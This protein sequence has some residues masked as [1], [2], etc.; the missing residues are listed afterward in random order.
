MAEQLPVN[1]HTG[2]RTPG[3]IDYKVPFLVRSTNQLITE[4]E[5]HNR[6]TRYVLHSFTAHNL[7]FLLFVG[8]ADNYG[9]WVQLHADEDDA[10]A[11]QY[12]AEKAK[13]RD[14][15]RE[16]WSLI[17]EAATGIRVF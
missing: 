6:G 5:L 11:W 14:G 4:H 7:V 15:D 13:L 3:P 9:T 17:V 2:E 1:T 10:I 16:G 12:L 8:W